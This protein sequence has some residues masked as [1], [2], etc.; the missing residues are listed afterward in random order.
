M[1]PHK[2]DATETRPRLMSIDVV[3]GRMHLDDEK[4]AIVLM[5]HELKPDC[6][7]PRSSIV[8]G[9]PDAGGITTKFIE[10]IE[11]SSTTSDAAIVS[12]TRGP[13]PHIHVSRGHHIC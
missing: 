8:G 7:A 3:I 12:T 13:V 9:Y 1:M 5:R 11:T 4:P 6:A 2:P 10:C